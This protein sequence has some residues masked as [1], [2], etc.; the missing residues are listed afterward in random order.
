MYL[1]ERVLKLSLEIFAFAILVETADTV[2]SNEAVG[3]SSFYMRQLDMGRLSW[4]RVA[5]I[6]LPSKAIKKS[7]IL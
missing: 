1:L 5:I 2:F 6:I 3:V 7:F 4:M